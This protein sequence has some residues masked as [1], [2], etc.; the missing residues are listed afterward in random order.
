MLL[1]ECMQEIDKTIA[2]PAH[3]DRIIDPGNKI[4]LVVNDMKEGIENYIEPNS[5]A[6]L[7]SVFILTRKYIC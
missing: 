1:I 2:S 6:K 5:F 4:I 3:L 7:H